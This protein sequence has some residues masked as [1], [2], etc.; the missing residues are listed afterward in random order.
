MERVRLGPAAKEGASLAPEAYAHAEQER[1]MALQL[2]A[3]GDEVGAE[4]HADRAMAA[5]A[6]ALA[7]ARLARAT[8]EVSDAEKVSADTTVQLEGLEAS[9]IK[10]EQEAQDL[11]R[12]VRVAEERLLPAPSAKAAAEREAARLV[13]ARS[14]AMDAR[15]LCDAVHLVAPAAVGLAD[16][17]GDVAKVGEQLGK[18]VHPVPIDDAARARARCLDFLTRA[19]RAGDETGATD[20]LLAELSA[21]GQWAPSR[22]ER[23]VIVVLHDAFRGSELTEE[24][25]SKLKELG[26]VASAH[27][28]FAIEVVIHDAQAR[29][30]KDTTDEA[31]AQ[32]AVQALVAGG[33]TASKVKSELAGTTEPLVD[34]GDVKARAR[35]ER[36]EIAFVA[37]VR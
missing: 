1:T 12:R 9:R 10:L 34:P 28:A 35:N 7:I 13:A 26:R 27:P 20:T 17:E 15:L 8:T 23:G 36:L 19:R 14:L 16:V 5:Y 30:A 11:E 2:H 33:A 29:P 4:L 18:P 6:H 22:D 32:A 25:T 37:A 31:R 3:S 21:S 24:G